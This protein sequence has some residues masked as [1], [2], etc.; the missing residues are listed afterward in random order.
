MVKEAGTA[1]T[2]GPS[3]TCSDGRSGENECGSSKRCRIRARVPQRQNPFVMEVDWGWNCYACRGFR[4]M[5]RNC[6][7][8]GKRGRV[9]ENK[10]VEYGGG[11]IE[12]IMNIMNNLK[13]NKN[14]ELLN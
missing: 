5:A 3:R 2:V 10:R 6:R 4:H 13:E 1:S 7:N 12:E 11:R 14:L 9:A 8:R